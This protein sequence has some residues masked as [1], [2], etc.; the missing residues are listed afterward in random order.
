MQFGTSAQLEDTPLVNAVGGE[1]IYLTLP[2]NVPQ[3]LRILG[4]IYEE[5]APSRFSEQVCDLKS[6]FKTFQDKHLVDKKQFVKVLNI[7]THLKKNI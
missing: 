6:T 7:Q 1:T 3:C 5:A 4:Q 2:N